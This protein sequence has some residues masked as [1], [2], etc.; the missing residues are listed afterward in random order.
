MEITEVESFP[1]TIPL[2]TPV[3]FATRTVYDR[4]H[5]ITYVRTDTGHEGVGY[6]SGYDS[7][8]MIADAV[9]DVLAPMIEGEDP[10]DTERLW[11]KMFDGT[12]QVGR[13]GAMLRAISTVDIALWDL[14]AKSAGMPLHKFLGANSESVPAYASGGYYRDEK[15]LDGLT[16]EME[17]YVDAGHD[18][19]KMKVG[20]L[21]AHEE[22]ERVRTVREA[23]GPERLLLMDANG[24]WSSAPEALRAC[25]AFDEYDPY[26]I[27]EPAMPDSLDLLAKINDGLEYSVATGELEATRYAFADLFRAEAAD[28]FQPDVTVIGGITEWLK[29]ANTAAS[30]DIPIA[31][32]YNWNLHVPLLC[33]IE[34][35]LW[36][37]YFYRDQD[38][39]V[40]D[41]VVA[42][43]LEPEDGEMRPAD[44]P[45]HGVEIDRDAV[46]EFR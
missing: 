5:T 3:S 17:R 7:A 43:P 4:D 42:D 9:T 25:R 26:F 31:P 36:I 6:T 1:V 44:R 21:S 2:K 38:V 37:E 29:V 41:D 40:F 27:E 28:V 12:V 46:A 23:I 22:A 34:N 39:V 15:G 45:G 19:V 33:S 11:H 8:D 16:E 24:A 32:H 18:V 13:R 35:G 30:F 14:S 20:R 10:R